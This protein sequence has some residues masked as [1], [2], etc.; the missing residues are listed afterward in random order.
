MKLSRAVMIVSLVA[1][2]FAA[3]GDP[4]RVDF[5]AGD[6]TF[7][8]VKPGTHI[9][10]MAMLIDNDHHRDR[11]QVLR[12]VD[13]VTPGRNLQVAPRNAKPDHGIWAFASL[14]G[15][16]TMTAAAPQFVASTRSIDVT[17]AEGASSLV[18]TGARA[19][20]LYVRKGSAWKFSAA[21]GGGLD[22]DAI[23]DGRIT[24]ALSALEPL[25]GNRPAPA[26]IERGDVILLID[27][28]TRRTATITVGQ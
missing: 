14:D 13:V 26:A 10:W 11:V 6:V 12:G 23:A 17:A 8:D 28:T 2:S 5:T 20:V 22:S 16:V 21:D 27:F 15:D 9:A 3:I 25:H 4:P 1:A 24:I 7:N 18:M 19:E